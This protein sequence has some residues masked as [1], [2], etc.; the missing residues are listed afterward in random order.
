MKFSKTSIPRDRFYFITIMSAM[1]CITIL[2]LYALSKGIDGA[3]FM[4][5]LALIGGLVGYEVKKHH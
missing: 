3:I 2:E 4:G 5:A 1:G